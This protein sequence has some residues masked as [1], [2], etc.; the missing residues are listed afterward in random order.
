[1]KGNAG[2]V[3]INVNSSVGIEEVNQYPEFQE[4]YGQGFNGEYDPNSF[5]PSWGAPIAE[6]A[7]TVPEHKYYD[8]WRQAME[9]GVQIDNS[10]SISGGNEMATFYG[11][12]GRMNHDGIIPF[13]SWDRTSAK[14][15]GQIKI[16]EKFDFSGSVNYINS[17]G[18]RVPHDRFME[19]MVYWT[20]TQDINN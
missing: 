5:W 11:S 3:R 1:K 18:N 8:N 19:R 12:L 7:Q 20:E 4:I 6:V 16:S 15:S 9:T 2:Q 14:L 13:S 10:V 17:G